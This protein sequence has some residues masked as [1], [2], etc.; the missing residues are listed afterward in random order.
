M[1]KELSIILAVVSMFVA[2]VSAV[3]AAAVTRQHDT[4]VR[5]DVVEVETEISED[6]AIITSHRSATTTSASARGPAYVPN[7]VIFKLADADAGGAAQG[8]QSEQ[9]LQQVTGRHGLGPTMRIFAN[10]GHKRLKHIHRADLPA[11]VSP[12]EAA[13]QLEADPT[14]EWAE[15]NYYRYT[16]E[17]TPNDPSYPSQWHLPVIGAPGAW[18]A[19]TGSPDVVVAVIDTGVDWDHPDL[20]ANIWTNTGE[21]EGDDEDNDNNGFIDDVRGW[22][23]V[24]VGVDEVYEGE[25]PGPPDNDPMDF[26][27]HGTHVS[28]IVGAVGNNGVGV[29]GVSWHSKIMAIRAGY[30]DRSGRGL[31]QIA[32]LAAALE[33]AADNGADVVNMSF[34][35]TGLSMTERIA[36]DYATSHGCILVAAAGNDETTWPC[37]PAS[38]DSVLSVAA[39]SDASDTKPRFSNYS[40]WVD[41]AAPGSSIYSTYFDDTYEYLSGT[42]MA[43]PVV[44][45]LAALLKS[46]HIGWDSQDIVNQIIATA[47]DI[48]AVNPFFAGKLGGGRVNAEAAVGPEFTGVKLKMVCTRTQDLGGDNDDE[49][50]PNE[51]VSLYATVKNF[52]RSQ[53]VMATLSTAD[54]WVTIIN[55]TV[56]YGRIDRHRAVTILEEPYTFSIDPHIPADH[57]A[58][59]DLEISTN[60]TPVLDEIIELRLAPTWSRPHTIWADESNIQIIRTMDDGRLL[61]IMD[62]DEHSISYDA[63]YAIVQELDGTWN[64]PELISG[65][66]GSSYG[67][68]MD[69]GPDGDAHVVYR[70]SNPYPDQ[71]VFYTRYDTA[72]STWSSENQLTT[73]FEPCSISVPPAVLCV[74]VTGFIHVVW[75]DCRSGSNQLYYRFDDGNNWQPEELIYDPNGSSLASVDLCGTLDGT[76]YLFFKVWESDEWVYYVMKGSGATWNDPNI[77]TGFTWQKPPFRIGDDIYKLY[78]EHC[79]DDL[80]LAEF[81][82]TDWV[83]TETLVENPFG[84]SCTCDASLTIPGDETMRLA[85]RRFSHES[86]TSWVDWMIRDPAGWS[87]PLTLNTFNM[88]LD[89]PKIS[90]DPNGYDHIIAK[91]WT[92][93]GGGWYGDAKAT[94]LTR[95]PIDVTLLP[96]RPVVTDDGATTEDPLQLHASWSTSH[97]SG[98]ANYMYAIGTAPG[99]ADILDW[100]K[101]TST[102]DYTASMTNTP[103]LVNQA[104]YVTI[105]ALSNA[106]YSSPT[107]FSDGIVFQL[108]RGD[109]DK[110]GDVDLNDFNRFQICFNGPNRPPV[111]VDRCDGPDFDADGDVDLT[112]FSVFAACFN[113]PNRPPACP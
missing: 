38:F 97:P 65:T 107:G 84:S 33:Y 49:L 75:S 108:F 99:E 56:S 61:A 1:L 70:R 67:P 23:F 34:G 20:A 90:V 44:A 58:S 82:G 9:L 8:I 69:F 29:V 88:F 59:F 66:S 64:S 95:S 15:P 35:S 25:D 55:D 43:S 21:V 4:T 111:L 39:T 100:I 112:D 12:I 101:F 109:F 105:R 40:L 86:W 110:D 63:I 85:Y 16:Q 73:D 57:V 103:L 62:L 45:G 60:G 93:L 41:V 32:D 54:P 6:G 5:P 48:D 52:A 106:V 77:I 31:L 76:R 79:S 96:P 74:D 30:K 24:S 26:H 28:G 71:E 98:I 89:N 113:G 47:D 22:D 68:Y 50:E 3:L 91:N 80:R 42:S 46:A 27:G 2:R 72:T 18:D 36:I 11:G 83:Y 10:N 92:P 13:K 37:Y 87:E 102:T 51:T 14:I 53:H 17:T 19:T 104:Y 81:D 94:Y 78:R 7:E